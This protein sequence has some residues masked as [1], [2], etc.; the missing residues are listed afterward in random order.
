MAI[1]ATWINRWRSFVGDDGDR[2]DSITNNA[3]H[4]RCESGSGSLICDS[5]DSISKMEIPRDQ[6]SSIRS[7]GLPDAELITEEQWRQLTQMYPSD[8]CFELSLTLNDNNSWEWSPE[9]CR[10]CTDKTNRDL[11]AMNINFDSCLLKIMIATDKSQC[12]DTTLE[13]SSR[14]LRKKKIK[15][16]ATIN[17]SSTDTIYEVKM[18]ICE[19]NNC[20]PNQQDLYCNGN[21]LSNNSQTLRH[22]NVT[23]TDTIF[24]IINEDNE[25]Y[26]YD[27]N[28]NI[29]KEHGFAGTMLFS[30]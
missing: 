3:L 27:D 23:A 17:A 11:E 13:T 2:P 21:Q 18:K 14:S 25:D 6:E 24:V 28:G 1:D 26:C 19:V 29:Q 22:Y 16:G 8:A 30:R 9:A 10:T 12:V 20:S 15:N 5:L 7:M 4:C